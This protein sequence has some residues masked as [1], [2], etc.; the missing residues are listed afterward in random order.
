MSLYIL[1][2]D[3]FT[4]EGILAPGLNNCSG[5][6][7]VIRSIEFPIFKCFSNMLE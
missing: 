3:D 6:D 1:E 2:K 7:G 4:L 5:F